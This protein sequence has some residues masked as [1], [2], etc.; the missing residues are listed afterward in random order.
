MSSEDENK[1]KTARSWGKQQV[2]NDITQEEGITEKK[3]DENLCEGGEMSMDKILPPCWVFT[4]TGADR[5][6]GPTLVKA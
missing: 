4:S 1:G 5:G 2:Q 3:T 6:P